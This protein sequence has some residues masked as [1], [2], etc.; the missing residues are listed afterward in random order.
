MREE[1]NEVVGD[2][3]SQSPTVTINATILFDF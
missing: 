2:E 1:K 3:M